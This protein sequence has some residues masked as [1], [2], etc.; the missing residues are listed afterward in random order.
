[1][2]AI[3]DALNI[4]YDEEEKRGIVWLN[5]VSLFFTLCAIGGMLIALGAVVVFPLCWPPL[6]GRRST[7]R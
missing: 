4:I 6:D 3:F 2:K 1:M 5:V 7:R